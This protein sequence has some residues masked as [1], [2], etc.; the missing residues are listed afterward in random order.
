MKF[1]V[2]TL[3]EAVF[4]LW[5]IPIRLQSASDRLLFNQ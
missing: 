1:E 4:M 3:I 2:N 5:S